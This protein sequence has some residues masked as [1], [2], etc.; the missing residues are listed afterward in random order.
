MKHRETCDSNVLGDTYSAGAAL[1]VFY[2]GK[3][4]KLRITNNINE[5]NQLIDFHKRGSLWIRREYDVNLNAWHES[6]MSNFVTL[7]GV[8]KYNKTEIDHLKEKIQNLIDNP[9]LKNKN[10]RRAIRHLI[11]LGIIEEEEE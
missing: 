10:Q 6:Q 1:H 7:L 3:V 2:W 9:D 5:F 11:Q 4:E 8:P